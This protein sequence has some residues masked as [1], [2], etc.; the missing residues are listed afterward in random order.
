MRRNPA[1]TGTPTYPDVD[2]ATGRIG[3]ARQVPSPNC[4][5][6]PSGTAIDLVVVHG[7][8]LPPGEFGGPW[9]DALFTNT[10][11]PEAH[12]YFAGVASLRV[13]S[14]AL[15]CRS[16]ELVQYVDCNRR[17]WHAGRSQWQGQAGCNDY[18]IGVELEGTDATPYTSSQYV[19]LSRLL[20]ALVRAYP[21]ITLE[22]IV[23]H[24]DVAP[25]RKTDPGIAFDWPMLRTLVR[26]ELEVSPV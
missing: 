8:S 2:P 23:G 14:H 4:D 24:S 26:Y 7:I 25:G 20:A 16:G 6:R 22:R 17:A 12:A 15:I 13:S 1:L 9:I 18:S 19:V 3:G 21:G 11:P 10:L 5:E